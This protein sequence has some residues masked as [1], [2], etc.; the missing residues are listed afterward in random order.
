LL[1]NKGNQMKTLAFILAVAIILPGCAASQ[2]SARSYTYSQAQKSEAMTSAT[3]I[4][5]QPVIITPDNPIGVG[6]AVGAIAGGGIGHIIGSGVGNTIATALGA[7]GGG[8]AGIA[9]EKR[10]R[11]KSGYN[12]ALRLDDGRTMT[13]TQMDDIPLQVGQKVI[14]TYNYMTSVYRVFPS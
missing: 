13:V 14:V 12:I 1:S 2:P 4:G 7:I 8:V 11:A 9:A 5:L 3:V 6:A 10:V